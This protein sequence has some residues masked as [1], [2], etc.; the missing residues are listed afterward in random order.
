VSEYASRESRLT[1]QGY[2]GLFAR[3]LLEVELE[4][5]S[6]RPDRLPAWRSS[7][8]SY[9]LSVMLYRVENAGY[10]HD[11][12]AERTAQ[13]N[14]IFNDELAVARQ[15]IPGYT[16]PVQRMDLSDRHWN[17]A[18]RVIEAGIICHD[19][20]VV[21]WGDVMQGLIE[22]T[23]QHDLSDDNVLHPRQNLPS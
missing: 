23:V 1:T 10:G 11:I 19:A 13:N 22:G 14:A 9:M 12:P 4:V 16:D 7:L 6:G 15:Y 21:T 18:A 20:A 3:R 5:K 8:R 17:G 2:V